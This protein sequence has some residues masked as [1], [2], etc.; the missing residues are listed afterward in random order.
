MKPSFLEFCWLSRAKYATGQR[1]LFPRRLRS[2]LTTR[3]NLVQ[4]WF[5]LGSVS[6]SLLNNKTYHVITNIVEREQSLKIQLVY[7]FFSMI[8]QTWFKHTTLIQ[9][10]T[11]QSYFARIPASF[12]S[13]TRN[14][15]SKS[16]PLKMQLLTMDICIID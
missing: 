11:V 12:Q 16:K 4:T 7:E 3:P 6:H 2:T 14:L 10:T 15:R 5:K 9:H 1:S 13:K 8:V